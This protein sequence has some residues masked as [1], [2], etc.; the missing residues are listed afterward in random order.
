MWPLMQ[1]KIDILYLT[2]YAK[3]SK[4]QITNLKLML[5]GENIEEHFVICF[6]FDIK[7]MIYQIY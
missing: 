1:K 4:K 2:P 7:N 6:S 3:V 5:L